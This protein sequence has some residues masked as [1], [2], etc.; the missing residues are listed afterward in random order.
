MLK[1]FIQGV[2]AVVPTGM[3]AELD[4]IN[5]NTEN[6]GILKAALAYIFSVMIIL[7]HIGIMSSGF[8]YRAVAITRGNRRVGLTMDEKVVQLV[9]MYAADTDYYLGLGSYW[10]RKLPLIGEDVNFFVV[11][12]FWKHL[13]SMWTSHYWIALTPPMT[14][15]VEDMEQNDKMKDIDLIKLLEMDPYWRS[16]PT[17]FHDMVRCEEHT[18]P[19]MKTSSAASL[20]QT[21]HQQQGDTNDS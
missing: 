18:D 7:V 17:D 8:M 19:Y 1:G 11:E 20:K 6:M 3:S 15:L 10:I 12:T 9:K 14:K 4:K 13:M 16:I 21:T 5:E 2:D